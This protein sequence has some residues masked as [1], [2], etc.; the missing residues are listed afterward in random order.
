MIFLAYAI[1]FR[2]KKKPDNENIKSEVWAHIIDKETDEEIEEKIWWEDKNGIFHDCTPELP[3]Y[4][5]RDI[6]T[7]W[8]QNKGKI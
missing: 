6:D 4:L 7:A 5:R 3:A 8:I 2:R 1:K